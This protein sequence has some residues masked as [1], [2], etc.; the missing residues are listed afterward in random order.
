MV[1]GAIDVGVMV[2]GGADAVVVFGL[3][4]ALSMLA[5]DVESIQSPDGIPTPEQ[6]TYDVFS[7]L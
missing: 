1:V 6:S 4:H 2:V 3:R 7:S 5:V